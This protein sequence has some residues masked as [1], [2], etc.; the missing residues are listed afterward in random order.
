MR[1]RRAM[2]AHASA[3]LALT[4]VPG[5]QHGVV[6]WP[7]Y[8]II[9]PCVCPQISMSPMHDLMMASGMARALAYT[10]TPL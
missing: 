1:Q 2:R 10:R 6:M 7:H 8:A 4:A 3:R 5:H 9:T